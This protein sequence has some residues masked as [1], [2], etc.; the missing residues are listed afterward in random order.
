MIEYN[1]VFKI[2]YPV[3]ETECLWLVRLTTEV[4]GMFY[5]NIK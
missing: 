1:N 3:M 5:D 2:S 4:I